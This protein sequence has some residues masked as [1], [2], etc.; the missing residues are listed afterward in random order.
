MRSRLDRAGFRISADGRSARLPTSR[1][2]PG[3]SF[4]RCVRRGDARVLPRRD[5]WP[6]P[7]PVYFAAFGIA[8]ASYAGVRGLSNA[9]EIAFDCGVFRCGALWPREAVA[10]ACSDLLRFQ[11]RPPAHHRDVTHMVVVRGGASVRPPI[12][13]A[14]VDLGSTDALAIELAHALDEM[15]D[16]ARRDAKAYRC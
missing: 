10:M 14:E 8:F 6:S 3:I 16:S 1:A 13:I 4:P 2:L 12:L 11:A 5:G 9:T 7:W 15:L